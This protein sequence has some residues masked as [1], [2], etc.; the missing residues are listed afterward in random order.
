MNLVCLISEDIILFK[1]TQISTDYCIEA[2][3]AAICHLG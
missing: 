2:P 3:E 1:E